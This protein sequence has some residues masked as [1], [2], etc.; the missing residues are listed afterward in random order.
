MGQ[1]GAV[2]QIAVRGCILAE[3]AGQ[4]R[5]IQILVNLADVVFP[6]LLQQCFSAAVHPACISPP[7][8]LPLGNLQHHSSEP[9]PVPLVPVQEAVIAE[10]DLV[11]RKGLFTRSLPRVSAAPAGPRRAPHWRHRAKRL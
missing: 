6:I 10:D 7:L 1:P 5:K 4:D 8:T 2:A 11:W 3:T 9:V